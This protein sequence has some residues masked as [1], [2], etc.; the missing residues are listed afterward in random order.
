MK[1]T[2]TGFARPA[3]LLA[4]VGIAAPAL[5]ANVATTS[6]T[7]QFG[8]VGATDDFG[9][10]DA[11]EAIEWSGP[12]YAE[13]PFISIP[14]FGNGGS[15][16]DS[17]Q[18]MDGISLYDDQTLYDAYPN[19]GVG[20]PPVIVSI[21][22]SATAE[23]PDASQQGGIRR[24]ETIFNFSYYGQ[25]DTSSLTLNFEWDALWS[26]LLETHQNGHTS[27]GINL[28]ARVYDEFDDLVSEWYI[29]GPA[30]NPP[31]N[32]IH[33]GDP[34]ADG[35]DTN[36]DQTDAFFG[37]SSGVISFALSDVTSGSYWTIVFGA[38][39]VSRA[40]VDPVPL[41]PAM[42]LLGSALVALAGR[43]RR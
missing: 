34:Y 9:D 7:F 41:P 37:P 15:S 23:G 38:E 19:Y 1:F 25:D 17:S 27:G 40:D 3:L 31:G 18:T 6:A 14:S 20:L 11:A 42:W 26:V 8:Y 12:P 4:A 28:E 16:A 30:G 5:A 10:A 13:Q 32:G 43:R 36:V 24:E 22:T 39:V 35:H 21:D 29:P 33:I 2:K